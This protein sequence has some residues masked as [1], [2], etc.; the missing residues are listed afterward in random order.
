M[1][2]NLCKKQ[3]FKDERI[4]MPE[5]PDFNNLRYLNE[6]GWFLYRD[7]YGYNHFTGSYAGER[8][9]WSEMLLDEL[10]SDYG[11]NRSWVEDK[12]V[13]NIGCGCT[14]EIA[15][16]PA[17]VKIAVDPLLY[18]Y[19]KLGML[20]DDAPGTSCTMYLSVGIEG[21]PL[22]D[23]SVDIVICRNALDHMPDPRQGLGQ[24]WRVLKSDGVFFLSV[25]IGGDP[26]P[27][28]P[29]PFT[30]QSLAALIEPSFQLVKKIPQ[31]KP[32][33]EHRHY[34]VR[35][36]AHKKGQVRALLDKRAIL[37]AYEVAVGAVSESLTDA[38]A[39]EAVSSQSP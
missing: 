11:K 6:V 17:A 13:L 18:T 38:P 14:G 25:D 10:T 33:N 1:R 36:V 3:S 20:I 8:M 31:P 15:A 28:E 29:S 4:L 21:L 27:D 37:H 39:A 9:I 16:W 5:I 32:H 23:E 7:T 35:V 19:Q 30:E 2:P 26:T 12:T 34:S 24:L 22:L